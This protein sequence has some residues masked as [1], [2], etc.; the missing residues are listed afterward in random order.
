MSLKQGA[1]INPFLSIDN[2]SGGLKK[3]QTP[4]NRSA[5]GIA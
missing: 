2:L 5:V 1:W 3:R 4:V